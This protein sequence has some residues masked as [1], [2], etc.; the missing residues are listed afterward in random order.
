MAYKNP[1]HIT[2]TVKNGPSLAE[3][4]KH[5]REA[6]HVLKRR[7]I[8]ARG[9]S[10]GFVF[11]ETTRN[12]VT[13][14]WHPHLHIIADGWISHED[15]RAEWLDITGDSSIVYVK[16]VA[17]SVEDVREVCKYPVKSDDIA[18]S[19]QAVLEYLQVTHGSRLFWTYGYKRNN[20]KNSPKVEVAIPEEEQ[21]ELGAAEAVEGVDPD[22][23]PHCAAEGQMVA[24]YRSDE[25][26]FRRRIR[27]SRGDV[28]AVR[29]GWYVLDAEYEPI[30]QGGS[31]I[32]SPKKAANLVADG[33]VAGIDLR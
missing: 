6:W 8:W 26:G 23:C 21:L 31:S 9:V 33:L 30:I 4:D 3:R 25:S 22:K 17:G 13:G 28:R 16:Q 12:L 2:L 20:W 11:W 27:W 14:E 24:Q 32:R 15:L 29:W 18:G 5:L 19:P 10:T 1:I 7:V